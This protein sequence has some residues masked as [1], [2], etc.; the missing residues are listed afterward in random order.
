MVNVQQSSQPTAPTTSLR[1]VKGLQGLKLGGVN[2]ADS[3]VCQPNHFLHLHHLVAALTDHVIQGS[4]CPRRDAGPVIQETGRQGN[5]RP[6]PGVWSHPQDQWPNQ[7]SSSFGNN[8]NDE[9]NGDEPSS[10][11]QGIEE[12]AAMMWNF[13][14]TADSLTQELDA[15]VSSIFPD[16]ANCQPASG[17]GFNQHGHCRMR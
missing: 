1:V 14:S 4:R 11:E 15:E 17:R 9:A 8:S 3:V 13:V 10:H 7:L 2:M 5:S 6:R 16:V 12:I